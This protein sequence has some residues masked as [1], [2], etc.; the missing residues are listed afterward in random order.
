MVELYSLLRRGATTGDFH[1]H[2]KLQSDWVFA[3][4]P[5]ANQNGQIFVLTRKKSKGRLKRT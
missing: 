3:F 1:L 5:L 4:S 2:V